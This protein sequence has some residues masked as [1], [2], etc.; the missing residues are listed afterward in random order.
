MRLHVLPLSQIDMAPIGSLPAELLENILYQAC[1]DTPLLIPPARVHYV[2]SK[3]HLPPAL[4]ISWVC[5]LWADIA[6]SNVKFWTPPIHINLPEFDFES[7][8]EADP[9]MVMRSLDLLQCYFTRSRLA[10][11]HVELQGFMQKTEDWETSSEIIRL[12][13]STLPR[14]KYCV[15]PAPLAQHLPEVVSGVVPELLE[16]A[17]LAEMQRTWYDID[18]DIFSRAPRLR[19]WRGPIANA[20]GTILPWSQ[21]TEL[22]VS[23][24]TPM[25]FVTD[26]LGACCCLVK[27][28]VCIGQH[29][30]LP[31]G[32]GGAVMPCLEDATFVMDSFQVLV[33]LLSTLTTPKLQRLSLTGVVTTARRTLLEEA[34]GR[35]RLSR[36]PMPEFDAFLGRS[37]CTIRRLSLKSVIIPEDDF[38]VLLE[39]LPFLS[40]FRLQ[41]ESSLRED[42]YGQIPGSS[43]DDE[44]LRRMTVDGKR[45]N[46]LLPRLT[47]WS[48]SGSLRFSHTALVDMV[49]SRTD[50]PM[51]YLYIDAGGRSIP[52]EMDDDTRA[53][54]KAAMGKGGDLRFESEA[55]AFMRVFGSAAPLEEGTIVD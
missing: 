47:R 9:K 6:L 48:I 2:Y 18:V 21:L 42:I 16:R 11:L 12:A 17:E 31:G 4:A 28:E 26:V 23:D 13:L 35:L 43:V 19:S 50:P 5:Q 39:R 40:D 54:L 38:V 8:D 37:Q 55:A 45:A 53:Q 27:L 15:I 41:E 44:L 51:E 46:T 30:D 32:I 7:D 49:R 24:F 3:G 20:E 25:T 52:Y 22:Y 34:Y 10:P 14:W 1:A 29:G 33:H 36:W